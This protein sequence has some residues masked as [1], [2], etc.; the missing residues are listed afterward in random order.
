MTIRFLRV[1]LIRAGWT[2]YDIQREALLKRKRASK[3][4]LDCGVGTVT[5]LRYF[6]EAQNRSRHCELFYSTI[7]GG[8]FIISICDNRVLTG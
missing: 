8:H 4:S 3:V 1:M 7:I 2:C 6:L 5:I